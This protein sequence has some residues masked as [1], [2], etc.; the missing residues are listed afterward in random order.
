M[1]PSL[2]YRATKA[3]NI[4][5][6]GKPR[7]R[8]PLAGKGNVAPFLPYAFDQDFQCDVSSVMPPPGLNTPSSL[9]TTFVGLSDANAILTKISP[10]SGAGAG[11]V[12]FTGS[13]A[14]V[15]ATWDDFQTQT[16]QFPGLDDFPWVMYSVTR[17]RLP[18]TRN[19]EVR[20]RH[21]YF[22]IDPDARATGVLD[23]GGAPVTIVASKG[24]IPIIPKQEFVGAVWTAGVYQPLV[25]IIAPYLRPIGGFYQPYNSF[26]IPTIPSLDHY[27]TAVATA[28]GITNWTQTTPPIF[29]G[30]DADVT[31]GQ[32]VWEASKLSIYE[33]NIIERVTPYVMPI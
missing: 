16:V 17:A 31:F 4:A 21:E 5:A 30:T 18:M 3:L 23:S 22:V 12:K 2:P 11:Q 33:G 32:Y 28:A 13:F 26:H 6:T 7:P 24:A 15:P 19:V 10:P 25:N 14:R 27:L 20:L 29:N 8:W 9:G 1:T